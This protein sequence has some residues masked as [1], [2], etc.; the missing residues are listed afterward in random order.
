M[1]NNGGIGVV[2][3]TVAYWEN[4][5]WGLGPKKKKT[6]MIPNEFYH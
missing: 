5:F 4:T 2:P 6:S 3:V 1:E